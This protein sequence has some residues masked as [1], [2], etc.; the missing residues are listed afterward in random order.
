MS[1]FEASDPMYDILETFYNDAVNVTGEDGLEAEPCPFCGE[2]CG[3]NI[4]ECVTGKGGRKALKDVIRK[5]NTG[6]EKGSPIDEKR[7][8]TLYEVYQAVSCF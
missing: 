8:E 5:L 7:L 4:R 1:K 3:I 2:E 6:F